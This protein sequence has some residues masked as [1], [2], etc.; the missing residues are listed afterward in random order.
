MEINWQV[1]EGQPNRAGGQRH[2][3]RVTLDAKGSIYLNRRAWE[4]FGSPRFVQLMHDPERGL[5]GLKPTDPDRRNAFRM[6]TH[7]KNHKRIAASPFFRH[8]GI[9]T[10][11]TVL[12][13]QP[14]LRDKV[15]ILDLNN[16]ITV[17]FVPKT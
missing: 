2:E 11:R 16:T 6:M 12:F 14:D 13:D 15:L 5:I 10:D 8:I 1:F 9:R 4:A 17:G 3:P 7:G